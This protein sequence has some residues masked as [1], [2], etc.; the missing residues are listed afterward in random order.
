MMMTG[1]IQSNIGNL[2]PHPQ[3]LTRISI[4][5]LLDFYGQNLKRMNGRLFPWA[6]WWVLVNFDGW[7][8]GS[9]LL[10]PG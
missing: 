4:I 5:N 9:Q 1:V 8:Q 2:N 3:N 7:G 6:R 10:I